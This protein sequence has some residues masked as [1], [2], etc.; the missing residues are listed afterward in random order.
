MGADK[1]RSLAP[2]S[3]RRIWL[4]HAAEQHAAG[5]RHNAPAQVFLDDGPNAGDLLR[6][7]VALDE[8]TSP[9]WPG[10]DKLRGCH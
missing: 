7:G 8:P 2:P 10:A 4:E 1:S 6:D 9:L 3:S 5:R